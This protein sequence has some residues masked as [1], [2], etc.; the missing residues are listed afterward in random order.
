MGAVLSLTC[1]SCGGRLQITEDL[2]RFACAHCGNEHLVRRG[3]GVVSLVPVV[4]EL[5]SIKSGVDRTAAELAIIR[6]KEEIASFV[7]PDTAR[8]FNLIAKSD[9]RRVYFGRVAGD[10]LGFQLSRIEKFFGMGEDRIKSIL[11]SASD[12]QLVDLIDR[13]PTK[14]GSDEALVREALSALLAARAMWSALA[15]KKRQLA[16]YLAQVS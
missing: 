7:F 14:K 5:R 10:V 16:A 13:I 4:Q 1:P 15:E 8:A 2:E 3:G 9:S 12:Q 11:D 6:L